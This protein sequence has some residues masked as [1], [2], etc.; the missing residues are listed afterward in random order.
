MARAPVQDPR[1]A[2]ARRH[3]AEMS[4]EELK[5][6]SDKIEKLKKHLKTPEDHEYDE[7]YWD[8]AGEHAGADQD[9][10]VHKAAAGAATIAERLREKF[11][12]ALET[13][14]GGQ[15]HHAR[16]GAADEAWLEGHHAADEYE[17]DTDYYADARHAHLHDMYSPVKCAPSS[18]LCTCSAA[19]VS[20]LRIHA[21]ARLHGMHS[22]FKRAAPAACPDVPQ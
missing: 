7:L 4:A 8:E 14:H 21:G 20:L 10:G 16:D 15:E 1:A 5:G 17:D 12:H 19:I 9:A 6:W 18:P 2:S 11:S 13:E 3:P 22:P